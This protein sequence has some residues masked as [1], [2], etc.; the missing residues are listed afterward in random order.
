[1]TTVGRILLN[2]SLQS[3]SEMYWAWIVSS[4]WHHVETSEMLCTKTQHG[5]SLQSS[6]RNGDAQCFF[7]EGGVGGGR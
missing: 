2:W 5:T 3:T 1:M 7:W 6:L 4:H